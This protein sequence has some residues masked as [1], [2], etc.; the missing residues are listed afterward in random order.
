[1]DTG[2]I[3]LNREVLPDYDDLEWKKLL[4][5][6]GVSVKFLLSDGVEI[7]YPETLQPRK[8]GEDAVE[9]Y[10]TKSLALVLTYIENFGYVEFYRGK[11]TKPFLEIKILEL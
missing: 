4:E 7:R 11:E 10:D 2:V 5:P 3:R 9:F 8:V 6:F 1:M